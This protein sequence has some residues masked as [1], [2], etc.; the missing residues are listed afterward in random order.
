MEVLRVSIPTQNSSTIPTPIEKMNSI[1]SVYFTQPE[2][3]V[4]GGR[5]HLKRLRFCASI[6]GIG[7]ESG[8]EQGFFFIFSG[9]IMGEFTKNL[10]EE[11]FSRY[12][13]VVQIIGSQR[14]TSIIY[15]P[16]LK[17]LNSLSNSKSFYLITNTVILSNL[18]APSSYC[19]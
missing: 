15:L 18:K 9:S 10:Y 11:E 1:L 2:F 7:S 8:A 14:N 4:S 12:A 19:V 17:E 6:P 3:R 16:K 5:T 13:K